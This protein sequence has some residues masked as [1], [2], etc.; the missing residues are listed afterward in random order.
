MKKYLLPEEGRFYKANLHM[1]TTVSDGQMTPEE[2]KEEYMKRGYSIIAYTDHEA[3]VPHNELSD[4]NFLAITS[5]E[6]AT[7]EWVH[8]AGFEYVRTYHLN[9]YAR[10]KNKTDSA[11]FT[12]TRMWPPHAVQYLSEKM[13]NTDF[14]REYNVDSINSVIAAANDD[15][16]IVT[17]NHPNWSL[18]RYEDYIGLKGLWAVEFYNTGCVRGGYPDTI[19]PIDDLLAK[20]ERVFPTATDDAHA[21]K[22]T[23]HDCFGGFTMVKAESLDYDTVFAALERGDHYSSS[24]PLIDELYIEDGILHVKTSKAA[25]IELITERRFRYRHTS[26]DENGITETTFDLRPYLTNCANRT[27]K[28]LIPYFRISVCDS[29]GEMAYTRAYFVDELD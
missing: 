13:K 10:D 5:Y 25:Y 16:F 27:E 14:R 22:T 12:M 1:H 28:D 3:L 19:Q 9:L 21:G 7:N 8:P 29:D 23:L 6:I 17:L 18:Q 4:D 24:G 26:K 20:G 2:V 11:V 15:G